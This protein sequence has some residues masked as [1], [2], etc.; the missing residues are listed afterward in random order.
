[1]KS[2]IFILQLTTLFAF[3]IITPSASAPNI[4]SALYRL[5]ERR[6]ASWTENPDFISIKLNEGAKQGW[7]AD[8]INEKIDVYIEDILIASVLI[9]DLISDE[10]IK[11]RT[12]K[13]QKEKILRFLPKKKKDF[14]IGFP[15]DQQEIDSFID[16]FLVS[17]RSSEICCKE[18]AVSQGH[19]VADIDGDG[20]TEIIL[21]WTVIGPTYSRNILTV[22]SQTSE[23]HVSERW[24]SLLGE[25]RSPSV[26]NGLIYADQIVFDK[27]DPK[28]CPSIKK[29]MKY[30]WNK[31]KISEVQ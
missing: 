10:G 26:K 24:L 6:I 23:G 21:I 17:Q 11:I 7:V 8:R 31:N 28:C 9:R 25:A 4:K 12:N 30:I 15:G 19:T 5:D 18:G 13:E 14:Y 16:N 1:M 3:S 20:V 2:F 22:F 27:K 29:Q